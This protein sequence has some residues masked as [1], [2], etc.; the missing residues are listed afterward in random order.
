MEEDNL[1]DYEQYCSIVVP[2]KITHQ[3][4]IMQLSNRWDMEDDEIKK[5][6]QVEIEI[7]NCRKIKD[8]ERISAQYELEINKV[9]EEQ[10]VKFNTIANERKMQ[11]ELLMSSSKKQNYPSFWSWLNVSSNCRSM[12]SRCSSM[13]RYINVS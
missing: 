3:D 7:L 2:P 5:K 6:T 11:I 13:E 9:L 4:L 10:R 1:P 12:A 8:V